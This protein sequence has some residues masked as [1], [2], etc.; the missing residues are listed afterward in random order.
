MLGIAAEAVGTLAGGVA[1]AGSR[2]GLPFGSGRRLPF[3]GH[4]L[5]GYVEPILL[6]SG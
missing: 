1:Q 4:D 2:L 3:P 6:V 5:E